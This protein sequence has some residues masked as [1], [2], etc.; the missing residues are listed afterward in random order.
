[1]KTT[2]LLLMIMLGLSCKSHRNVKKTTQTTDGSL[3][4][5]I[6]VNENHCPLFITLDTESN[7]GISLPFKKVFPVNLKDGMKKKGLKVAFTY[8][9]SKAMQPEGCDV[10]AV[11]QLENITVIP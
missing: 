6:H 5:I 8:T 2:A 9:F 7:P 1:M 4:G 10:E 3:V 11:I